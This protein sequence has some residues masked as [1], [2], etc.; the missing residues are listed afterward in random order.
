MQCHVDDCGTPTLR[1]IHILL[2]VYFYDA[3]NNTFRMLPDMPTGIPVKVHN[4]KRALRS[5][6]EGQQ[7]HHSDRKITACCMLMHR[8]PRACAC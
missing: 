2:V 8:V 1:L 7:H 5:I 6:A 4:A 3:G